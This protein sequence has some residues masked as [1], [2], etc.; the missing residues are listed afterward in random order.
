MN[1]AEKLCGNGN[2]NVKVRPKARNGAEKLFGNEKEV[3]PKRVSKSFK[4]EEKFRHQRNGS[5]EEE[6]QSGKFSPV[7][8]LK[9]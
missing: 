5:F 4:D 7:S 8:S 2:G 1:Q 3:L 9:I 6:N